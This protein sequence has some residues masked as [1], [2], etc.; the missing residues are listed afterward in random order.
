ESPLKVN[1]AAAGFVPIVQNCGIYEV[2]TPL[3]QGDSCR[4]DCARACISLARICENAVL[5]GIAG[6]RRWNHIPA[7]RP[8]AAEEGKRSMAA[9]RC[10]DFQVPARDGVQVFV[11]AVSAG[12]AHGAPLLLVHGARVPG[13]GSF[14]LPVAGGSLA[15]D[16]AQRTG[17]A[18]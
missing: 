4:I 13:L 6:G 16:L 8:R 3:E 7:D 11:R 18:V 12:E 17:R 14:D 10:E 9:I 1:K 15:A 2:S 5:F